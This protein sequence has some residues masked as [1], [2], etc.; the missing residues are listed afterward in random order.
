MQIPGADRLAIGAKP[1]IG[2]RHPIESRVLWRVSNERAEKQ[3][4]EDMNTR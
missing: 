1:P 3:E 4:N 2:V